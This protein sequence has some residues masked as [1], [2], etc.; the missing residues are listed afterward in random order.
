MEPFAWV[1]PADGAALGEVTGV[2]PEE[3]PVADAAP[4]DVFVREEFAPEPA[5]AGVR[6]VVFEVWVPPALV[7]PAF[8]GGETGPVRGAAGGAGALVGV[9]VGAGSAP[10]A[11][12]GAGSG[13]GAGLGSGVGAGPGDGLGSGW[14]LGPGDGVSD[15][16]PDRTSTVKLCG[17]TSLRSPLRAPTSMR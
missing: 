9:G 7:R 6:F 5:E 15:S 3:L 14:G 17:S 12:L 16:W 8:P 2:P 11:G 4:V 1:V 13:V 10:G